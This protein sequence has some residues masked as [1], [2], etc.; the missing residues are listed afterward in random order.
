MPIASLAN[1]AAYVTGI[2]LTLAHNSLI[3]L[4]GFF[5]KTYYISADNIKLYK[6][7]NSASA[8]KFTNR[9]DALI[10]VSVSSSVAILYRQTEYSEV[11]MHSVITSTVQ[12]KPHSVQNENHVTT[13]VT[14]ASFVVHI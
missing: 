1:R 12:I 11:P 7:T 6:N 13:S 9:S 5:K 2:Y 14:S 10:G 8:I 3:G 4:F